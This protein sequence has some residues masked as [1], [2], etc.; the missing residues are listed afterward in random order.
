MIPPVVKGH[1]TPSRRQQTLSWPHRRTKLQ[2]RL[3]HLHPATA[4]PTHK[5]R[6]PSSDPHT[7]PHSIIRRNCRRFTQSRLHSRRR[8]R[9][10]R[11]PSI[12]LH[13]RPRTKTR[14]L[15]Q[16]NLW[17]NTMPILST[18]QTTL[19]RRSPQVL[20]APRTLQPRH[21]LLLGILVSG[22][23]LSRHAWKTRS[24]IVPVWR[25]MAS[26]SNVTWRALTLKLPSMK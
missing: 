15:G 18:R 3:H 10:D 5:R 2:L 19:L 16:Q 14:R 13:H 1:P 8:P 24:S 17:A 23:M 9:L 20:Q 26:R 25:P 6:I 7:R 12:L 11:I 21:I 22:V 4:T